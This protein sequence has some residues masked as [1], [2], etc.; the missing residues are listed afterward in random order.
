MSGRRLNTKQPALKRPAAAARDGPVVKRPAAAPA[1]AEQTQLP[2]AVVVNLARRADRWEEMRERLRPL[3]DV[4]DYERVDA[5]DGSQQDIP[6]T[7]VSSTWSTAGN[8]NYVTKVFEGGEDCGYTKKVLVLTP[9]ERGCAASHVHIWRSCV[10]RT[11][12]LMILEDDAKPMASFAVRIRKAL[13]ELR[14]EQPDILYLGYTQA[15]PWRRKV[16]TVVREAE[17][18]W[19]TVGYILWPSGAQKLLDALPIDQPVDN[20]M[21]TLMAKGALRGFAV[22]PLVVKQA[23]PW[24]VDNDVRHSDDVAW[25]QNNAA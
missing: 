17:Y 5:V 11:D 15:A 19:T 6:L 3:K 1:A 23:K 13:A 20:Y 24:N 8:W 4:L 7:V 21:A 10:E 18:L 16:G 2:L 9:G 22:A 12:P 25:V 14:G